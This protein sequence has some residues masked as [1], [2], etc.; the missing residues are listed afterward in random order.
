MAYDE[1]AWLPVVL[2]VTLAGAGATVLAAR[3]WGPVAAVRLLAL[4]L[5]PLGLYWS[6]LLR[7][8]WSIGTA[9]ARF[10]T[11]LVLSPL[12]SLGLGLLGAAVALWL[13]GAVMQ[14]RGVGAGR[15]RAVEPG[16]PAGG[17]PARRSASGSGEFDDVEEIL[18]R[19][20]IS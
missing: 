2:V 11:G 12:V 10:A 16:R 9:V 15:R 20:G 13:A 14:R 7:L 19:R 17:A 4:A 1:V 6:G 18:R 8:M 3:R 5:V